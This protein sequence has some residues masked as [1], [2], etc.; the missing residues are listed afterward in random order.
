[1]RDQT[2]HSYRHAELDRLATELLASAS[3]DHPPI[4]AF[5][6]AAA[7]QLVV[8]W[9]ARQTNRARLV[10]LRG[11]TPRTSILLRPG[12]RPER[13]QWSVAH[14]IAEHVAVDLFD[15]TGIEVDPLD[16]AQRERLANGLATRLFL[17][18]EWFQA[19]GQSNDWDVLALK[20]RYATASYELIARRML[21]FAAPAI[22]T[23]FDLGRMT[24]RRGNRSGGH[25]PTPMELTCW[26]E[27]HRDAMPGEQRDEYLRVR[28]WPVH[29]PGWKREILR[30]EPL[31]P[32]VEDS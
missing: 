20:N 25:R 16:P 24:F 9:D 12:D 11:R 10:R 23:I 4:D 21:D 2:Q 27:V 32:A 17:P 5:Q 18:S 30:T 29:E 31:D 8:A 13:L 14:E 28:G 3:I 15:R 6:V 1:M 22:I 19:D 7:M 26:A